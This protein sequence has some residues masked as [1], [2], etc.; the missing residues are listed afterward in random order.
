VTSE[1]YEVP[2]TQAEVDTILAECGTSALLVGGQALAIWAEFFEIE[3]T[4]VLSQKVTGDADFIG[5]KAVAN[6][7]SLALKWNLY[8]PKFD[9]STAQTAKVATTLPGGGVKQ[10]D[11]FS[12]IV[13]LDTAKVQERA[14]EL[15]LPNGITVRV[16]SPPDVLESRLRNLDALPEKQ[17]ETGIA[18]AELAIAVIAKFFDFLIKEDIGVRGLLDLVKRLTQI[19]FNKRL[20][21][22]C[23]RYGLD[24]LSAVPVNKIDSQTFRTKRWPQIQAKFEEINQRREEPK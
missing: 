21:Q 4:G 12:S 14:A 24:P 22:V 2:L 17:N 18:Q 19:A 13:G 23:V 16:L 6:R 1:S 8:L 20:A 5:S 9:D 7:L 15:D 10:V 3:P 11:F